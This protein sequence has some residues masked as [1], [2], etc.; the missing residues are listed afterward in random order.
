MIT[1]SCPVSVLSLICYRALQRC[2]VSFS[3][4]L[5]SNSVLLHLMKKMLHAGD[6]NEG[7]LS[8]SHTSEDE[9]MTELEEYTICHRAAT[10]HLLTNLACAS[11]GK[12]ETADMLLRF[13]SAYSQFNSGFITN[14]KS[15]LDMLDNDAHVEI[16]TENLEEEM[17]EYG[18]ETLKACDEVGIPRKSVEG[19]PHCK[20]F[21]ELVEYVET[22]LQRSYSKFIPEYICEKLNQAISYAKKQGKL[23]LLAALYFGSEL[24]MPLIYSS[25]LQGLRNSLGNISN[26]DAKFLIL[27]IDMDQ[28][29]A[30]A[31]R[32]I[33]IENCRT[34]AD[35]STLVQCTKMLLDARVSFY[36]CLIK[37]AS[38]DPMSHDTSTIYNT[39]VK[40][41]IRSEPMSLCDFTGRRIVFNMCEDHVKGSTIL[42]VAVAR[43]TWQGSWLPRELP[44]L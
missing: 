41:W 38:L 9:F 37:H 17:G 12:K 22:V 8:P 11:F 16:L 1:A 10:H 21:K 33:I 14:V 24:I 13:L 4:L 6:F 29:H 28:D 20:L 23:G 32:E 30:T 18:E 19:I 15:L 42:D 5:F 35:R 36:D 25:L 43:A 3:I 39:E 34:K 2:M 26:E 27:H 40:K 31:L 7:L 44:R